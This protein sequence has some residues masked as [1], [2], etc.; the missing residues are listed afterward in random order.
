[1]RFSFFITILI[2]C[3][4]FTT[5]AQ[6]GKKEEQLIQFSGVLVSS[7][8]LNQVSYASVIDKSTGK[9]TMS[10]YYGYFSFVTKPG[11]TILFN[12]FGFKTSSYIVPDSLK[13][14]R[15]S[16]IHVMTPDTLQ[17]PEVDVYPWPSREEFARAFVEMDPYDDALRRAQ[18]QLSGESLAFIASRVPTDGKLSYNWQ[19][20]QRQTQIY[21]Q[22]QTPINNLLNPAAW[23]QFIESW[24]N[25]ELQRE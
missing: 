12:A 9:G 4:S 21:T 20:E 6:E 13:E 11:D 17:L 14:S 2:L 7:D 15:Y 25:G 24:K 3:F 10:D 5:S 8:S 22:G 19:T 18:K 16:I 23:G 1:M